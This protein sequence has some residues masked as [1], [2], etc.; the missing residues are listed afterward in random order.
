LV[1]EEARAASKL[2]NRLSE[3]RTAVMQPLPKDLDTPAPKAQ[4]GKGLLDAPTVPPLPKG[5]A[6][7]APM[8]AM[9]PRQRAAASGAGASASSSAS[10]SPVGSSDRLRWLVL[11]VVIIVST[12]A[13]L[14]IVIGLR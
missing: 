3:A 1:E 6:Q 2:L 12:F 8:T 9:V 13:T 7:P 4:S 14:Y 5:P 11:A 10:R